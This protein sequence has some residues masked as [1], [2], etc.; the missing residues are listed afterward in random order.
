MKNIEIIKQICNDCIIEGE[1][2]LNTQWINDS[3]GMLQIMNPTTYV[4]LEGFEKW[5]SNCNVL[6]NI[7]GDLSDPWNEIFKTDNINTLTN[8]K[9]MIGGLK[10]IK[11][12]LGKGYLIRIEDLIFAEAFSNLIEQSEYLYSQNYFLAAGVIGRAVLEEKLRNLCESQRVVFSKSRPTLSDYN[13]ELYKAKFYSKP[14][15]KK[16]DY[17]ISIGNNAA[18]NQPVTKDEIGRLIKEVK[19]ILAKYK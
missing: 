4:N 9:S 7:L 3:M 2:L 15:L 10:S 16:I 5:K 17:L 1:T 8:T 11:D 6:L 19:K 14:E 12:N 13:I 18:H